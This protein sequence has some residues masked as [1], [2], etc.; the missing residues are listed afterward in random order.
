M[1]LAPTGIC[2]SPKKD[3]YPWQLAIKE[4]HQVMPPVLSGLG[5]ACAYPTLA[6]ATHSLRLNMDRT[7]L[8][9]LQKHRSTARAGK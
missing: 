8:A 1:Q 5:W 9:V 3:R 6:R 4:P 2:T 7:Q